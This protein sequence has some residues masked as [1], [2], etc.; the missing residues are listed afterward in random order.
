MLYITQLHNYIDETFA[1]VRQHFF[2]N[3][4]KL[5]HKNRYTK[6]IMM[7]ACARICIKTSREKYYIGTL[8]HRLEK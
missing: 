8:V 7:N 4:F 3:I 6:T 1:T 2:K 5:V